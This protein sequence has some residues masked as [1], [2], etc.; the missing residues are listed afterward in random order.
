MSIN[1]ID[2]LQ[3]QGVKVEILRSTRAVD[4]AA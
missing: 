2:F 3:K 1:Q 4:K